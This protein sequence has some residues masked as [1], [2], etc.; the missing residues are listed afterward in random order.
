MEL[1]VEGMILL[2][3]LFRFGVIIFVRVGVKFVLVV[4]V[5]VLVVE[6]PTIRR[7]RR[8]TSMGEDGIL[9]GDR[10]CCW[11][12]AVSTDLSSSWN[13]RRSDVIRAG[14]ILSAVVVGVGGSNLI[15]NFF[16][17]I[18]FI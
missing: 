6:L 9:G 17:M 12:H 11:D 1:G 5:V 13:I 15:W 8:R 2:A 3:L 18:L 7:R 14:G 16:V 10:R 4:V